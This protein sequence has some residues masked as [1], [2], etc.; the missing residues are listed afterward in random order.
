MH[1]FYSVSSLEN[2]LVWIGVDVR[3]VGMFIFKHL[4]HIDWRRSMAELA[5]APPVAA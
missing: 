1:S 5:S 4:Y 2:W 3:Y